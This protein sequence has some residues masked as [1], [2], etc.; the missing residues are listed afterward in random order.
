M[1]EARESFSTRLGTA[2][3]RTCTDPQDDGKYQYRPPPP[4]ISYRAARARHLR[5]ASDLCLRRV[6]RI[7]AK[8]F[9]QALAAQTSDR[10]VKNAKESRKFQVDPGLLIDIP[11]GVAILGQGSSSQRSLPPGLPQES[12]ISRSP[13]RTGSAASSNSAMRR[14]PAGLLTAFGT[15]GSPS[16]S[17]ALS[18]STCISRPFSR[19]GSCAPIRRSAR[20]LRRTLPGRTRLKHSSARKYTPTRTTAQNFRSFARI[21][22]ALWNCG[23]AG[24]AALPSHSRSPRPGRTDQGRRQIECNAQRVVCTKRARCARTLTV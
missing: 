12:R 21:D 23:G 13:R 4:Q 24:C 5:V 14:T 16:P 8:F 18:S 15:P 2:G 3:I 6:I 11:G 10:R 20:E 1:F 9:E 22:A 7:R 19:L 17:S